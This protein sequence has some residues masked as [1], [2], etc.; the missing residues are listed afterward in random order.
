MADAETWD[1][2]LDAHRRADPAIVGSA[3]RTGALDV[4][5]AVYDLELGRLEPVLFEPA[6]HLITTET[7]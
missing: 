7:P 1:R 4:R 3:I 6:N 2:M 5:G